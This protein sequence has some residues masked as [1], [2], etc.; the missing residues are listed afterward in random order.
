MRRWPFPPRRSPERTDAEWVAAVRAG[1]ASALADLRGHLV[2]ALRPTLA[3]LVPAQAEAFGEDVAQ[4]ALVRIHASV[5]SYRGD[6]RFTTWAVAVAV[7][8]AFTEL[9]RLRWRDVSLDDL[10]ARAPDGV[11]GVSNAPAPDAG[12]QEADR[13]RLLRALIDETLTERQRT[14]LDAVLVH[15]MA[16][17][18]VAVRMGTNRNALYKLLHDARLRLRHALEARGLGPDDLLPDD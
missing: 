12:V 18:Q 16:L 5:A 2:A 7:R 15:G 6:A 11:G 14:A 9:R 17:E 13:L 10:L 4:D 3:R 8:L 1:D